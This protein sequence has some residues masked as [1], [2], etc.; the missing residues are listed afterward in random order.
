MTAVSVLLL[1]ASYFNSALLLWPEER[2]YRKQYYQNSAYC[3]SLPI[4]SSPKDEL[5]SLFNTMY[6]KRCEHGGALSLNEV[7]N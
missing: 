2:E 1:F 4:F 5:S 6:T 3:S 7:K